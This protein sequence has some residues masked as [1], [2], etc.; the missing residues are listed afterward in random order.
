MKK[1]KQDPKEAKL[2]TISEQVKY[3]TNNDRK[4][5]LLFVFSLP[6]QWNEL[7]ND[8]VKKLN[9]DQCQEVIQFI[10]E[11]PRDKE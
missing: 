3:L 10:A 9:V 6:V 2:R 8:S 7:I 11:M 1:K 4:K 5:V